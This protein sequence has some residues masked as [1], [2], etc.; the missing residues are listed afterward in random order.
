MVGIGADTL[1][2]KDQQLPQGSDIFILG[3]KHPNGL[4]LGLEGGRVVGVPGGAVVMPCTDLVAGNSG[5]VFF[6]RLGP[7]DP[8]GQ[9]VV[10]EV[11][12][13]DGGE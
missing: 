5:Q 12:I 7:H 2:A 13:G 9:V 1:E 6:N 4:C 8:V 10:V 11:G 3:G